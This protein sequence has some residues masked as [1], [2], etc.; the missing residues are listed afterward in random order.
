MKRLLTMLLLLV[1]VRAPSAIVYYDDYPHNPTPPDTY[2][3]SMQTGDKSVGGVPY[4]FWT[5][6]D[7]TAWLQSVGFTNGDS[8]INIITNNSFIYST[9]IVVES[10][11]NTTFVNT[12]TLIVTSNAF[13]N[14]TYVTNITI[15]VPG[16]ETNLNLTPNSLMQSDANDA[17]SSVPNGTGVLTN[18]GAGGFG[19]TTIVSLVGNFID[20]NNGNGTNTTLWGTTI[21]DELDVDNAYLTNLFILV[22]NAPLLSTDGDG[23]VIS[24]AGLSATNVSYSPG[25]N[26]TFTTNVDG[27]VTIASSATATNTT[28]IVQNFSATYI[29]NETLYTTNIYASTNFST[30]LYFVTGKGNT[31]VVTNVAVYG[32]QTNFNIAASSAVITKSDQVLTNASNAHGVFTNTATGPPSFGLLQNT[33]LQ[34]STITIQ[35]S[36]VA[37]G[38][39]TLA[40]GSTPAFGGINFTNLGYGLPT[41]NIGGAAFVFGVP[42]TAATLYDTNITAATTLK[43]FDITACGATAGGIKIYVTCSGGT[44]RILTFPAG[45]SGAGLGTPP[46]VTI[47]NSKA[48]FFDVIYK[49][50]ATPVTNVFWSPV[51]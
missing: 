1:V 40:A 21:F 3:L 6:G 48:A 31:L 14:N 12:N 49:P 47:T 33:E 15:T 5:L 28:L 51:Y 43:L 42:G 22:T 9:N 19:W 36:A 18:D 46:A 2:I 45:C 11:T 50:G 7:M 34:N 39:T 41:N 8:S 24:N 17:E 27:S 13:F 23:K 25:A 4:N 35:G 38:G 37:L 44:D 30:N 32:V 26:M 10:I 29:T 20:N 16:G